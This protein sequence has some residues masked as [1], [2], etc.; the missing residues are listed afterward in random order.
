[1]FVS[2]LLLAISEFTRPIFD[3]RQLQRWKISESRLPPG[4]EIRFREPAIWQ[5][6]WGLYRIR[7]LA[8]IAVVLAQAA[9][10]G[11]LLYERQTATPG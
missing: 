7:I 1:M 9:L 6:I 8:V 3:W 2:V 10:I 4:S 11:G 5:Q